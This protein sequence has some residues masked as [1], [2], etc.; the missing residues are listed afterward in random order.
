M[1]IKVYDCII[2]PRSYSDGQAISTRLCKQ[3]TSTTSLLRRSIN[4]FNGVVRDPFEGSSYL[5]PQT[6]SWESAADLDT[7]R[8]WEIVSRCPHSFSLPAKTVRQLIDDLNLKN[9]AVEEIRL[10]KE[11]ML[12]V[13]DFYSEEHKSLQQQLVVCENQSDKSRYTQGCII[14]LKHR[15]L[16]CE[17]M[18]KNAE[19]HFSSFIAI[20]DLPSFIV[21]CDSSKVHHPQNFDGYL[22]NTSNDFE[23]NERDSN[24]DEGIPTADDTSDNSDVSESSE[25]EQETCDL[26]NLVDG[27]ETEYDTQTLSATNQVLRVKS[28]PSSSKVA[29]NSTKLSE[30][31]PPSKEGSPYQDYDETGNYTLPCRLVL[32]YNCNEV[33]FL[34]TQIILNFRNMNYTERIVFSGKSFEEMGSGTN[35][36]IINR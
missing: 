13:V 15:L 1:N 35:T 29:T 26:T 4:R 12:S 34:Y 6:L 33:T 19:M 32:L 9:R 24:D 21:L 14:L 22:T 5:L 36:R 30:S 23:E 11:E 31:T 27:V 28:I 25:D 7:L 16:S 17:L 20:P 18:L 2:N 10:L 8:T 3:I